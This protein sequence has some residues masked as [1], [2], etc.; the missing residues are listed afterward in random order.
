MPVLT[1]KKRRL[2]VISIIITCVI[3]ALVGY[4]IEPAGFARSFPVINIVVSIVG[5]GLLL[6]KKRESSLECL[7]TGNELAIFMLAS[8][9]IFH[10]IIPDRWIWCLIPLVVLGI[11]KVVAGRSPQ[12]KYKF[13]GKIKKFGCPDYDE[14]D[15]E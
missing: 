15:D 6:L 13:A 7:F 10:N 4:F 3:G 12:A 8:F 14:N 1:R 5:L 9:M 2:V 11:A